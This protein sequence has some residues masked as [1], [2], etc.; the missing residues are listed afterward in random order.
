MQCL[1]SGPAHLALWRVVR[2]HFL[3]H[4]ERDDM[5][6]NPSAGHMVRCKSSAGRASSSGH[7]LVLSGLLID[8]LTS[9]RRNW[10]RS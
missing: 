4:R 9:S 2:I 8:E 5:S 10:R 6:G 1:S 3:E 7:L